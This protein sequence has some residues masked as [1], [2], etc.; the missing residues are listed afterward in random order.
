MQACKIHCSPSQRKEISL[1]SS[2]FT[3]LSIFISS[4]KYGL[5]CCSCEISLISKLAS[6]VLSWSLSSQELLV[7]LTSWYLRFYCDLGSLW[8]H[9]YN[10]SHH[11]QFSRCLLTKVNIAFHALYSW[12]QTWSNYLLLLHMLYRL[13]IYLF[14]WNLFKD[15]WSPP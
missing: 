2:S 14:D 5:S 11:H 13:S 1:Q 12:P 3:S 6:Q 8:H 15:F 7:L 4:V 10:H 9:H